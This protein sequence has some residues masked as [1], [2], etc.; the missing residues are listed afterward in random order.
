M[1]TPD[2]KI[3]PAN[4]VYGCFAL[5]GQDQETM[6]PVR[7]DNEAVEFHGI[8][9]GDLVWKVGVPL[10]AEHG[11]QLTAVQLIASTENP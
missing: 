1:T 4:A 2:E 8:K 3:P 11:D 5:V 6:R 10:C 9:L 7:C